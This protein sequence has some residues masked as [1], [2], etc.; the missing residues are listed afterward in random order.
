MAQFANHGSIGDFPLR[1]SKKL[2]NVRQCNEPAVQFVSF[3]VRDVA[4]IQSDSL[5]NFPSEAIPGRAT[6]SDVIS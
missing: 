1:L 2:N 4:V 6:A 5:S 3:P